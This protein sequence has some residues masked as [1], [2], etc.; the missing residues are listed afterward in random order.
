MGHTYC[1]R[2][3]G[4]RLDYLSRVVTHAGDRCGVMSMPNGLKNS[5]DHSGP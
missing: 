5:L 4:I 2:G 3:L 1:I